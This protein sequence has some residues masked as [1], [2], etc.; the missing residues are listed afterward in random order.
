ME[1]EI[2]S[3]IPQHRYQGLDQRLGRKLMAT[4][5]AVASRCGRR[6]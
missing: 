4:L 5:S 2:L 3:A 1:A 6:P